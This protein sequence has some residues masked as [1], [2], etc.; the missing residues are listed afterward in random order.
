MNNTADGKQPLL[1]RAD[2]LASRPFFF[3]D[4]TGAT[5]H[6]INDVID[7][8][9]VE[10]D[11]EGLLNYLDFGYS[12]FGRTSIKN[13][14]FLRPNQS[15]GINSL[16]KIEVIDGTDE[17]L[18]HFEKVSTESDAWNHFRTDIDAWQVTQGE[19]QVLVPMS[20]GYD[21]RL[22]NYFYSR[23]DRIVACT[24][25]ISRNQ[26]DSYEV[27]HAQEI[28]RRLGV[29][30][31]QVEL[32]DFHNYIEDWDA[33]YGTSTHAHGMYHWE[34]FSK[35]RASHGVMPMLSGVVGDAWAGSV[36][37]Q[38]PLRPDDLIKLGHSHG[39]QAD[40]SQC[41]LKSG[42]EILEK[43]FVGE[44][45]KLQDERYRVLYLVRTKL[46]LLSYLLEV[47][48]ALGFQPYSPFLKLDVAMPMLTIEST[49]W[50]NRFWQRDF[51]DKHDLNVEV[52]IQKKSFRN[53]LDM[54]AMHRQP[55]RPLDAQLLGRL[56]KQEYVEWINRNIQT[57]TITAQLRNSIYGVRYLGGALRRAGLKNQTM[58]AYSAYVVLRP[59]ESVLRKSLMAQKHGS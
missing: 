58:S 4:E 13:V 36:N 40:S 1:Y 17:A 27:V 21:S 8:R 33:L 29:N 14:H 11:A 51:M 9:N 50:K 37:T 35:I 32:G 48:R 59:I 24:Y 56:F 43:E 44:Q 22:I 38:I 52:G 42:R 34:F 18:G 19:Q 57:N 20:G 26:T 28:C 46:I 12:V 30:W 25:G 3:N 47:P 53:D 31:S 41:L 5:S 2:W 23:K 16:G 10:F 6:N 7:F 49:R 15:V 39:V 55:L 54:V 45:D